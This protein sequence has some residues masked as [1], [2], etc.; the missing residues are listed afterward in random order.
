MPGNK[1]AQRIRWIKKNKQNIRISYDQLFIAFPKAFIRDSSSRIPLK[2]P[3][4]T[5]VRERVS[6]DCRTVKT[7]INNY[8]RSCGHLRALARGGE[9][10]DLHGN[11]IGMV[12]E[13]AMQFG[14]NKLGFEDRKA[15]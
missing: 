13:E 5:E 8:L 12:S 7:A 15:A 10:Y 1:A 4:I 9:L 2:T 6:G 11:V 3:S 14:K